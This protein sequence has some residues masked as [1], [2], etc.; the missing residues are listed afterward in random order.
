MPSLASGA[1]AR[2]DPRVVVAGLTLLAFLLR[3][4]VIDEGAV[5]DELFLLEIVHNRG[6]GDVFSSVHETESTPPLHFILAWASARVGGDDFLW[7]KVPSL[8]M[9]TATVPLIYVLGQRTVGRTA[10]LIAAAF[11]A[12]APF[13]IYYGT[14]GRAY[15][16]LAFLSAASTLCLVELTRTGRRAWAIALVITTTAALYTHYTAVFVVA[17]QLG[18][19]LWAHRHHAKLLLLSYACVAALYLPWI[20]SFIVQSEDSAA[21]RIEALLSLTVGSVFDTLGRVLIGHPVARLDAVPGVAGAVLLGAGLAF[22]GAVAVAR[23]IRA[24]RP[25]MSRNTA[26]LVLLALA[27][28]VGAFLYSLGPTSV[29]LPRNLTPS[30]P[31]AVL[32][33]GALLAAVRR[34]LAVAAATAAVLGGLSLGTVHMLQEDYGRAAFRD[35]ARDLD[36]TVRPGAPIIELSYAQGPLARQLGFYFREAHEY[37][38]TRSS[39]DPAY[40]MGRRSGEFVVVVPSEGA[41]EFMPWLGLREQGF[42][43]ASV[44]RYPGVP[45]LMVRRYVPTPAIASGVTHSAPCAHG[46]PPR[47]ARRGCAHARAGA[48]GSAASPGGARPARGATR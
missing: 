30:I 27:T 22:A 12:L 11:F 43:L 4:A 8:L 6:L 46:P 5:F 18:W 23:T 34:P 2:P 31:A 21:V 17:A 25:S 26:L 33:A 45:E 35:V 24:R 10:A 13:D 32:L 40:G 3:A 19:A 29:F 42:R 14:E 48:G 16:T 1:L 36:R 7:I 41:D 38:P 47:L 44:E 20:P 37:F 39:L 9:S 28:P 15:A